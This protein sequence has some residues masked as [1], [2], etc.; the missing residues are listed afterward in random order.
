MIEGPKFKMRQYLIDYGDFDFSSF[1]ALAYK[2]KEE[3]M[4]IIFCCRSVLSRPVPQ[5]LWSISL[6]NL[7]HVPRKQLQLKMHTTCIYV[8]GK[9]KTNYGSRLVWILISI[10]Q[11][12]IYLYVWSSDSCKFKSHIWPFFSMVNPYQWGHNS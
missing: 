10:Y 2:F 9:A 7:C 12:H 3:K 1:Q 5:F 8:W 4:G 11:K 6:W